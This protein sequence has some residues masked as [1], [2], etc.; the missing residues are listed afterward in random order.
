MK[1][2]GVIFDMDGV[3][4]NSEPVYRDMN[5]EI[6]KHLGIEVEEK[7]QLE[8]IGVTKWKKW[9]L[10]K[11]R[12]QLPLSIEELIEV[13]RGFFSKAV[14]DYKSLLFPQVITLLEKL[15]SKNI[16]M[17]LASS[18]G[19]ETVDKVLKSC[20]LT[21]YLKKTVSGD[22]VVNGK[23]DPEIFLKAAQKIELPPEQCIV[24]EDSYNGLV[25]AKK[26]NM[27]GIGVRH[28]GIGMDLSIAD[29]VVDSLA[30]IEI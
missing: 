17:A 16:P 8:Y 12:Y 29:E 14:W 15:K 21:E 25:A 2:R 23:P 28:Q 5:I 10:L 4:I 24:I 11:E 9:E 20:G 22:E 30:E 3:I 7:H 26:A 13:Q 19:R 18:S 6:F 1:G 27:Y